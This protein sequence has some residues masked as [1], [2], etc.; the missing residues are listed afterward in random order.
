MLDYN[1]HEILLRIKDYP[2]EY[3][4]L[5]QSHRASIKAEAK[6]YSIDEMWQLIESICGSFSSEFVPV[7]NSIKSE[8][9]ISVYTTVLYTLTPA[10]QVNDLVNAF[11]DSDPSNAEEN[12]ANT[13]RRLDTICKDL[14]SN[15]TSLY[16]STHYNNF[17]AMH[18]FLPFWDSTRELK[19]FNPLDF[20][21]YIKAYKHWPNY[22]QNQYGMTFNEWYKEMF[23]IFTLISSTATSPTERELSSYV[24][25]QLFHPGKFMRNAVDSIQIVKEE[26][27][28]I[29][30]PTRERFMTLTIPLATIP[31]QLQDTIKNPYFKSLSDYLTDYN[32]PIKK[33]AFRNYLYK[34]F[35]YQG[36]IFPLV[37]TLFSYLLFL[38]YS[39]NENY[40]LKEIAETL[41][42]YITEHIEKFNYTDSLKTL[43]NSF[44]IQSYPKKDKAQKELLFIHSNTEKRNNISVETF[45]INYTY[46]FFLQN[47]IRDIFNTRNYY[48][49]F[50]IGLEEYLNVSTQTILYRAE[51]IKDSYTPNYEAFKKKGL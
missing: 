34:A 23:S 20:Y 28:S 10:I 35:F 16:F 47:P 8:I 29:K 11:I 15:V 39:D 41:N 26:F 32:N 37:K 13:K 14:K 50:S 2:S 25:E 44:S 27:N 9:L 42:S 46:N 4:D 36:C 7:I 40:N 6:A 43:F 38:E 21:T 48:Q 51:Q 24:F 19:V 49:N 30:M 22:P 5:C 45:E 12:K 3:R 33:L 18:Y 1:F 31:E 17:N